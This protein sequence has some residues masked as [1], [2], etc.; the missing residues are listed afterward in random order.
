MHKI[1]HTLAPV[2]PSTEK[3]VWEGGGGGGGGWVVA[4]CLQASGRRMGAP[5]LNPLPPDRRCAG[6]RLMC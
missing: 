4:K 5:E 2:L 1:L 3:P 6:L